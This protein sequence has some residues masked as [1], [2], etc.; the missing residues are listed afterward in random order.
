MRHV[1]LDLDH[2]FQ[3]LCKIFLLT[4]STLESF[5]DTPHPGRTSKLSSHVDGRASR[6]A[7]ARHSEREGRR[8]SGWDSA[9]QL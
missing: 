3:A 7:I 9:I 6:P 5:E 4:Y 8:F 1:V 2:I